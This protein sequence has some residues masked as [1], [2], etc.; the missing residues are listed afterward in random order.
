LQTRVPVLIWNMMPCGFWLKR[1]LI[2][3]HFFNQRKIDD[4]EISI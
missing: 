4:I 3:S 1:N 2:L